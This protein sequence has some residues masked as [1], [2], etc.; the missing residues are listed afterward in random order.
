LVN[1]QRQKLHGGHHGAGKEKQLKRQEFYFEM[2]KI[3]LKWS[4]WWLYTFVNILNAA[5]LF[6]L[7]CSFHL[8]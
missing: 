5:E 2:M 1:P 6:T 3:S 7:K 8:N 4:R